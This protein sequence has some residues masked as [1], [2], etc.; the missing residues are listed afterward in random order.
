MIKKFLA[1]SI[2]FLSAGCFAQNPIRVPVTD[3]T[4]DAAYNFLLDANRPYPD[5]S[6]DMAAKGKFSTDMAFSFNQ[7]YKEFSVSGTYGV[8]D[9]INLIGSMSLLTSNYNLSSAKV[10]GL[11]DFIITSRFLL[12]S[13]RYFSH[14]AQG[15]VKIPIAKT[16]D[17]LGTGKPDYHLAFIENYFNKN[18]SC[19]LSFSFDALTSPEF[20]TA[21]S[22]AIE[23]EIDSVKGRY[24]ITTQNNYTVA[25]YPTYYVNDEFSLSTGADFT[26][27]MQLNYNSSTFYLGLGLN[28]SEK[29]ILNFGS[30]FNILNSAS[31]YISADLSLDL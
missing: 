24:T 2:L 6:S 18:L 16:S 3:T 30:S 19:D 1:L 13:R 4:H 7:D 12:G 31:Y 20:P 5:V 17:Q 28:L 23:K 11:G 21:K 22:T 8:T 9:N 26:R 27:D 14:F 29:T 25:L 10:N 15:S